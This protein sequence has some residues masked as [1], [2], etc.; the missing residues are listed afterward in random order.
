MRILSQGIIFRDSP[1]HMG[2]NKSGAKSKPLG[3]TV[4][5]KNM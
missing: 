5:V 3:Y 1:S 2:P 4:E